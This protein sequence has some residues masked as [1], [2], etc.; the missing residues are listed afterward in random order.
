MA[1][2]SI[3]GGSIDVAIYD[4]APGNEGRTAEGLSF[5]FGEGSP[6]PGQHSCKVGPRDFEID[7]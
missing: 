6:H 2:E 1:V 7:S 5:G 4:G 3:S